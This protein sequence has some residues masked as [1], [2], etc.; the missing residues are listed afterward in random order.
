MITPLKLFVYKIGSHCSYFFKQF[1]DSVNFC[2]ELSRELNFIKVLLTLNTYCVCVL[3]SRLELRAIE[4]RHVGWYQC[5]AQNELGASFGSAQLLV[6]PRQVT[7]NTTRPTGPTHLTHNPASPHKKH[8][9]PKN[10]EFFL[11][12]KLG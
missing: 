9:K 3:G 5:M 10:S 1:T 6:V 2:S 4:K 8:R 7:F 12:K 11:L